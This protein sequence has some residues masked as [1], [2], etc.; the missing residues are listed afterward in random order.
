MSRIR[1]AERL[2]GVFSRQG[3]ERSMW[4]DLQVYIDE[5]RR[6]LVDHRAR[7][8]GLVHLEGAV[9][10][11]PVRGTMVIDPLWD[12]LVRYDLSFVAIDGTRLR[13]H[14]QK[15]VSFLALRRTMTEL[16]AVIE[17]PTGRAWATARVHFDLAEL[18]RFLRSFRLTE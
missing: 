5:P 3:V 17:D 12:R 9:D 16:P 4:L 18:G 15:D 13:F 6:F 1:F 11:A 8:E 2:Y 14:G 10:H 7:L